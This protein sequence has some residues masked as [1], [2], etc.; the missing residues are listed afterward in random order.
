M[1]GEFELC[2]ALCMLPNFYIDIFITM[3]CRD[4]AYSIYG[5]CSIEGV[6]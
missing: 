4:D 2:S 5:C 3:S 6:M 1:I